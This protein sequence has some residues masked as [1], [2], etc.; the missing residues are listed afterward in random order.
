MEF[1][2]LFEPITINRVVVPNRIVMPAMGL[3]FTDH[4]EFSDRY[5]AFYRA[6]AHGGVGLMTIGPL[7]VDKVGSA[8]FMPSIMNDEDVEPLKKFIDE[9]HRDTG[10]KLAT[11]LFHMGRVSYS[12]LFGE[13]PIGPSPIPSKLTRQTPREMTIED[14]ERVQDAFAQGARRAREAGFDHIEAVGCTGYLIAQF[15]SPISNQRGDEYGGSL[16]NRMRF[17]VE[18]IRK[19]RD[20]VGPETSIGIRIA[21][22]DFM[23]GGNTN[24][25]AS[26][27]A[28]A[29]EGAGADAINVT[30][31]W[32]ET[33][34]PQLTTNVPPGVFTYLAAGVKDKV[35]VPVFASNRLGDPFVAE[36]TLRAGFADMI[37]WARP[38]IAD[39][40]LPNKVREGRLDEIVYCIA[41]NQGCFDSIFGGTSVHC[42]VNPQA[43]REDDYIVEKTQSPK[44][45]MVAGGG[46]AGMEFAVVAAQRGHRVDL[47]EKN[48]R[49]GGQIN[50]AKAPPGKKELQNLIDSLDR[51][52]HLYGVNVHLGREVT[53]DLVQ[54][55]KPQ[56]LVVAS[57]AKPMELDIP[58]MD[59]PHVVGAWDV[60]TDRV[61]DIGRNVVVVG[62]SATGC[63]T[64]HY[65][66]SMGAVDPESFTFLMYHA[67]EELDFVKR[68]LHR[69]GRKITVIEMM[70]RVAENVGRTARWSLIKSLRLVGVNLRTGTRLL[71]I[72]DDEVVV[73]LGDKQETIPADTVIMA[74]GAVPVNE[75]ARAVPGGEIEIITIGDAKAPRKIT[76]AVREG[77]ES[78]LAI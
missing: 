23:E 25:E 30:G 21:G 26:A 73:T 24:I 66:A 39:P 74:V 22:N 59:K 28:A 56:V 1:L 4:Y 42:V 48:E 67:A 9:I 44:K 13:T 65:I 60:L 8:P 7:A 71:E 45:V 35:T 54:A 12:F 51:R 61:A 27:F 63:E 40:E 14:I 69:S 41:C 64:A 70:D 18:I 78:A 19:M 11:Q 68:L 38:M 3:S 10:C 49:L 62:G 36:K 72:K 34:V 47:Y 31:G 46:P 77:L 33:N 43:G 58:G 2:K 76:E 20:A 55:E 32:H 17:G 5:Q 15:L 6:R 37:C 16:E 29:A 53:P 75:L 57:G 50:M 52:M